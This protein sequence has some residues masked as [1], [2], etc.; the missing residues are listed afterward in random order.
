MHH[1]QSA[2]MAAEAYYRVNS[3]PAILSVTSGPGRN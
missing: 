3:K 1:E 2:A